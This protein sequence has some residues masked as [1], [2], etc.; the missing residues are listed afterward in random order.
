MRRK[1][2]LAT[3][4]PVAG[5]EPAKSGGFSAEGARFEGVSV[6]VRIG[7]AFALDRAAIRCA[8]SRAEPANAAL[9]RLGRRGRGFAGAANCGFIAEP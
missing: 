1:P 6:P 7:K 4:E 5:I 2:K 9:V 8:V 3:S